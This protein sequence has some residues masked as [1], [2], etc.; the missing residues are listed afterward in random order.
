MTNI[1]F[2]VFFF[3]FFII[4]VLSD[5]MLLSSLKLM[6]FSWSISFFC[7]IR[8]ALENTLEADIVLFTHFSYFLDCI[9][10]LKIFIYI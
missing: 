6:C 2:L 1:L 10:H 3:G 8:T 4:S 9:L 5:G 7:H